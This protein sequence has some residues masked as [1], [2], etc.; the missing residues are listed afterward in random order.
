MTKK[1]HTCRLSL[2][3]PLSGILLFSSLIA[4]IVFLNFEFESQLLLKQN[5]ENLQQSMERLQVGLEMH[6]A[7]NDLA[8][9]KREIAYFYLRDDTDAMVLIDETGQVLASNRRF[10]RNR[11]GH[12]VFPDFDQSRFEAALSSFQIIVDTRH[13][14]NNRAYVPLNLPYAP[15]RIRSQKRAVLYFVQNTAELHRH[16]WDST[17]TRGI[18]IWLAILIV[19]LVQQIFFERLVGKPLEQLRKFAQKI[20]DRDFAVD[21]PLSGQGE[22]MTLGETL[23]CTS[24]QLGD[25]L[26][27]LKQR[28]QYLSTT[29]QSIG[30]GIIVTDA[31]GVIT[32]I[33]ATAETLL[34]CKQQEVIG[35][36][37]SDVYNT[38]HA[39]TGQRLITPVEQA[40]E[41]RQVI[42]KSNNTVL[43]AR[44]G[45]RYNL[46][47]NAAPIID[48]DG[49]FHGVIL[50]FE[51]VSETY[52]LRQQLHQEKEHFRHVLDTSAAAIYTLT[53]VVRNSGQY[54]LAYASAT[55]EKLTGFSNQTWQQ[56]PCFWLDDVHPDDRTAV[57]EAYRNMSERDHFEYE[58]RFI[59]S[60]RNERWIKDHLIAIKGNT[61]LIQEI[62]GAW[63]DITDNKIRETQ[64]LAAVNQLELYA[65]V[66][67]QTQEG[68]IICDR[69]KKIVTVNQ[70]FQRITGYT[71]HEAVGT[72]PDIF[73]SNRQSRH[74]YRLLWSQIKNTGF[75]QGELWSRR[76]NGETY[77]QWLTISA[78][79]DEQG[80]VEYYIAIFSDI[81]HNKQIEARLQHL[82]HY[83]PLTDLP[84]RLLLQARIEHGLDVARS[85][86]Q[87][88]A[89]LFLDLD[90]FKNINDSLG[91]SIGDRLLIET[92]K[93]LKTML[94]EEDTVARLGGDEF[95]IVLIDTD[96]ERA[97][98]FADELLE[99]LS[100]PIEIGD[101]SF[102]LSASVG[103]S[104]FP[105]QGSDY[106]TLSRNADTALY[107][108]KSKGRN[109]SQLFTPEM[110]ARSQR[111]MA[112]EIDLRRALDE[113]QLELY[114]Q[115]QVEIEHQTIV[116]AEALLRWRHPEWG[117]V[118]PGEFIPV[119]E[120]SGLIMPIGTWVLEQAAF[121]VKQWQNE[122]LPDITIAVNLSLAQFR[123][124][125]LIEQVQSILQKHDLDPHCLELELT[126]SIAMQDAETAIEKT[127][128]LSDL[129]VKLS[130][131]DFGTGYS[132][133]SYLQRLP[134][135][136]L[137]IDQSFSA[138]M[139][140]SKNTENIVDAIIGL[141]KNL[142]LKI[143][144][145]GVEDAEQLAHYQHKGCDMIQ[146]YYFSRPIPAAQFA[147][148]LCRGISSN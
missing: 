147:D 19:M 94:N 17:L 112:L 129:G 82:A 120:D 45:K 122:G 41:T 114:Y 54:R 5:R 83:D 42:H 93:R 140:G 135:H 56:K 33:N 80:V 59:R 148:L 76:K 99:A 106:E 119:A 102:H 38:Y 117:F 125:D 63:L 14:N 95:N 57:A 67:K 34:A 77:P 116:G 31:F 46:V 109:Q 78:A 61:G 128:Q 74:F 79:K 132:S 100:E 73:C 105:E 65:K 51:D 90:H 133:L 87:P 71:D 110:Q 107:Q 66:F 81:T 47:S 18:L 10:W 72:K 131:D 91:H 8:A 22:L 104:V 146:G 27:A 138:K 101:Y 40:I 124:K 139:L 70:A 126:E 89:L 123:Q 55:L 50:V 44:N 30:S 11:L 88:L 37:L 60:D 113:G 143:I 86:H 98:R 36:K 25:A 121:Q 53:P 58:F 64:R 52:R 108:A 141:A 142:N 48:D 32:Q 130:I 6:L 2:W 13:E 1:T 115:P 26:T 49:R 23:Q 127:Q 84:N 92:G 16:I 69:H 103:I 145:E 137:K 75:W 21:N 97:T 4:F 134:I 144:A 85:H 136:K 28:E 12:Q 15:D 3:L 96:A 39:G 7:R 9:L 118:S 29:L 24:R 62:I 68:V 20:G 111:R 43:F 35:R